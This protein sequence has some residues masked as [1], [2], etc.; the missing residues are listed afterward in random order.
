MR[1]ILEKIKKMQLADKRSINNVST[2]LSQYEKY[3]Q[4]LEHNMPFIACTGME[5]YEVVNFINCYNTAQDMLIST[6]NF[7][8]LSDGVVTDNAVFFEIPPLSDVEIEEKHIVGVARDTDYIVFLSNLR[9]IELIP[10]EQYALMNLKKVIEEHPSVLENMVFVLYSESMEAEK[11]SEKIEKRKNEIRDLLKVDTL[12]F[13]TC[14]PT[15]CYEAKKNDDYDKLAESGIMQLRRDFS[16][17]IDNAVMEHLECCN[18]KRQEVENAINELLSHVVSKL[19][20]IYNVL[21]YGDGIQKKIENLI[22]YYKNKIQIFLREEMLIF[23][24]VPETESIELK[25]QPSELGEFKTEKAAH[26]AIYTEL[27]PIY[28]RRS[29][30]AYDTA[31]SAGQA[32]RAALRYANPDYHCFVHIN[33]VVVNIIAECIEDLQNYHIVLSKVRFASQMEFHQEEE[34]LDRIKTLDRDLRDYILPVG[35]KNSIESYIARVNVKKKEIGK[36]LFGK[37]YTYIVG[38]VSDAVQ[39]MQAQMNENFDGNKKAVWDAMNFIRR[40]FMETFKEEI[41]ERMSDLETAAKRVYSHPQKFKDLERERDN[42]LAVMRGIQ[43]YLVK[44]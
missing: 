41:N 44:L 26:D 42:V 25:Y 38:D 33:H 2:K 16:R 9:T 36:G 24:Q 8:E 5:K 31:L 29:R 12:K 3:K 1:D 14:F 30:V 34:F 20:I 6:R 40:K 37:K 27:K 10:A 4:L 23:E 35:K 43:E 28:D 32:F 15:L 39:A 19:N 18:R 22:D 21:S 13:Y 7:D 17:G 11:L